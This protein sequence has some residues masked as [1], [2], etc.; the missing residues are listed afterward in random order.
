MDAAVVP[1]DG[2]TSVLVHGSQFSHKL[3]RVKPIKPLSLSYIMEATTC[4][5]DPSHDLV[6]LLSFPV[7]LHLDP[8][9]GE[10][11]GPVL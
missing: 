4:S 6:A 3:Y 9:V 5:R 8:L 11:P 10:R 2:D 7:G 1:E